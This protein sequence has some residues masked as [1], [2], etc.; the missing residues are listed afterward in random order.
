MENLDI[1]SF[2][3]EEKKYDLTNWVIPFCEVLNMLSQTSVFFTLV[4]FLKNYF[5][6][7][8]R[9]WFID[10]IRETL[11]LSKQLI[12]NEKRDPNII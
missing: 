1:W 7:D 11:D 5:L 6:M 10:F 8:A 12:N 9:L 2:C 4:D 3:M